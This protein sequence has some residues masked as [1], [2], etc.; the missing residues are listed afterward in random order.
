MFPAVTAKMAR[1]NFFFMLT[2]D[3]D[4]MLGS[5]AAM[6]FTRSLG[7]TGA[8]LTNFFAHTPACC[9][10]RSELLSGRNF[11]KYFRDAGFLIEYYATTTGADVAHLSSH[12]KDSGNST[13]IGLRVLNASLNLA[14]FEFTDVGT[15][16]EFEHANFCELY[17]L[18]AD[19]HQLVN[20]CGGAEGPP[21]ALRAA[22]R[23]ELYQE[24]ACR[25]ASCR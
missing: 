4:G 25:A 13:F 7:A 8:N 12:L 23:R 18:T 19:P 3:Q 9:P 11:Y 6:S 15:D 17:N 5:M 1:P 2:D 16:Y 21:P 10:S 24:Y 20:L 22:L 14:Y